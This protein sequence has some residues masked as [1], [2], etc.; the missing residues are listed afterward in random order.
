MKF[1]Q[2]L[3]TILLF[4][5]SYLTVA[6][7]QTESKKIKISGKIVE[8][9]TNQAL[10]YATITLINTNTFKPVS[11]AITDN[12]GQFFLEV[13]SG[14]YD[15]KIEFISYEPLIL[16]NKKFEIDT[17]LETIQLTENPSKL[18]EVKVVA[19]KSNVEIKL[20]KKVYNVGKDMTVKGGNAADVLNN[21]P[22]V[23]VDSDGNVSLRGNENVKI[24]IDGRPSNAVNIATAMQAIPADAIDK[25]EVIS[26]PSARYDAEGGAGILN[27]VLKKGKTDGLNGSTILTIG[28]PKNLNLQANLNFKTEQ[29]NFFSGIGY[30][31][32]ISPGNFLTN[33]IYFDNNKNVLRTINE[34]RNNDRERIGHNFNFGLDWYLMKNLTW[35]N[36]LNYR[37]SDGEN[38]EIV[39]LNNFL[40]TSNFIRNRNNNQFN[41]S[42]NVEYLTNFTK[43]FK[44]EGHKLTF[45]FS[46][47]IDNDNDSAAINDFVVGQENLAINTNSKNFQEQYKQLIQTDYVLPLGK[48]QIEL[49]FKGDINKL[50][51]NF[52]VIDIDN[53]GNSIVNKNL[54]NIF[55]YSENINAVYAQ[56]GSKIEKFSYLFGI[57]YED[58]KIE[59]RLENNTFNTTKNY[60]NFFPSAFLTYA[61]NDDY[62]LSINYSKR[63]TRPRNRFINPFAGINNNINFFQG[64]PDLDPSLTDAFDLGILSK[65]KKVTIS[66]S[67]Y[68]NYTKNPFQFVRR[69]NGD[70][71][72]GIAVLVSTPINLEKEDRIGLE[73]NANFSIMKWWK[74]NTNFNYF[75]SNIFGQF[76]YNL[77]NTNQ[78]ITEQFDREASNWIAKLNSR[79]SLP[80]KIDWQTNGVYT[81]PQNTA[82]GRSLGVYTVN[83]AFSKDVLKDKATIS[84][85]VSDLFNSTKMIREFNLPNVDSYTEMQRRVRQINLSFTYRFNKKKEEKPTRNR[86]EEGVDF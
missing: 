45:D 75:K 68:Y 29:F 53:L 83:L 24:F 31:N 11:G 22:S 3:V 81:A 60:D 77:L 13:L 72:N 20:D 35:T 23:T 1:I 10:E 9:N 19:E 12:Q 61:V 73:V 5:N 85:N 70:F 36:S 4:T 84:F 62:S 66:G 50:K 76:R 17:V 14:L 67:V 59:S 34:T 42:N 80:Y 58:S 18:D 79:I 56:F 16:K 25:V 7:T 46:A 71:I 44:K 21:V 54:T 69:T 8:K 49:G 39:V 30:T 27:I 41:I 43:K 51:T 2:F 78:P 57:R 37:N 33:N 65:I 55:N 64:N 74:I 38:P 86:Q 48:S 32:S 82:Q 15:V 52:Q 28:N 6:Q 26:N 63:I 47:S 40:P